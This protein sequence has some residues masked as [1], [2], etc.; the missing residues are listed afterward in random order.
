MP[1]VITISNNGSAQTEAAVD[2]V[3]EIFTQH[4]NGWGVGSN[5]SMET[6]WIFRLEI[7]G[8][9][10]VY[11]VSKGRHDMHAQAIEGG[12]EKSRGETF[13]RWRAY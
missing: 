11:A 10:T 2:L 7:I 4:A 6:C 8:Q 12:R 13:F 1:L 9:R 3:L 5:F